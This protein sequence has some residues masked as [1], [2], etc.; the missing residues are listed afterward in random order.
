MNPSP[1]DLAGLLWR[2]MARRD[3]PSLIELAVECWQSDGGLAFM[4]EPENLI[5]RYFPDMP[6]VV[7]GAFTADSHLVACASVHLNQKSDV[8]R[9]DIVGQVRPDFRSRGIGT[10]LMQWS[11][12]QAKTLFE[13]VSGTKQLLQVATESL[14]EPA[15]RL[16]E[17]NGFERVFELLVMRRDFGFPFPTSDLPPDVTLTNWQPELAEQFFQAYDPAF[18]DRPGFPGWSAAEWIAQVLANDFKPDWSFLARANGKPLGFVIGTVDLTTDPP[19]GF[20]WQIGVIPSQR[21][22]GIGSALMVETMRRMQVENATCAQLVVNINNP[23]AI[24]S[25]QHL[26]FIIAGRRARYERIPN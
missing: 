26:G 2:P 20:V 1:P 13:D 12:M 24:K 11:Q 9:A 8:E 5:E 19:D 15:H 10:Y 25:Y 4:H 23:G 21:R 6:G 7:I 3:L 17:K 18:R 16:Y 14:T 22:Q